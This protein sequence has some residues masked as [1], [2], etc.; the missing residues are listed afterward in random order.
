MSD[1]NTI[2]SMATHMTM[3]KTAEQVNIAMLNK[4]KEL[5][6]QQGQQVMALLASSTPTT[7]SVTANK[8]DVYV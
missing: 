1:I 5:Q 7:S 6:E 2:A 4:A 3:Q 8:V